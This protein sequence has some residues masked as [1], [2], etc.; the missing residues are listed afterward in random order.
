MSV[1]RHFDKFRKT[2]KDGAVRMVRSM[3]SA[4]AIV[5]YEA[6]E[7]IGYTG[8]EAADG[9]ADTDVADHYRVIGFISRP[10]KGKGRAVLAHIGGESGHPAVIATSD[11]GTRAAIIDS[12]KLDWDEV[13]VHNSRTV[14]KITNDGEVLIG[15]PDDPAAF[16]PLVRRSEFV[17]H[18]HDAGSF[19]GYS[20]TPIVGTSGGASNI[21]G[22]KYTRSQ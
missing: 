12:A 1:S 19:K 2:Y 9:S 5:A 8:R 20:S 16:E 6:G 18:A 10:P 17:G 13:I 4:V 7:R 21:A 3:L 14:I 15:N 11:D 22:T